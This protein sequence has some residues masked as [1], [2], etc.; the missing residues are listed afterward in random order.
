MPW[1]YNQSEDGIRVLPCELPRP[2]VSIFR[3]FLRQELDVLE[4]QG[5]SKVNGGIR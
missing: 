5:M 1:L 4:H 2:F 3:H